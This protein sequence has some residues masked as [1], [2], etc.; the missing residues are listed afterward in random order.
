MWHTQELHFCKWG[1]L[2]DVKSQ[3]FN[4]VPLCVNWMSRNLKTTS[5]R[6]SL[7][8]LWD[9]ALWQS[10]PQLWFHDTKSPLHSTIS[11]AYRA[12]APLLLLVQ[13]YSCTRPSCKPGT[14]L[15]QPKNDQ[16][17]PLLEQVC[18]FL[19]HIYSAAE[20]QRVPQA[21]ICLSGTVGRDRVVK[22]RKGRP[23]T[24]QADTATKDLIL[25]SHKIMVRLLVAPPSFEN[26]FFNGVELTGP[27]CPEVGLHLAI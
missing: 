13:L 8:C 23:P 27:G 22:K 5:D 15:A 17:K 6:G 18:W 19:H 10:S 16:L 9:P 20:Q 1:H 3:V 12:A 2:I 7:G 14:E 4:L 25:Q 21:K 24:L 26:K 11:S